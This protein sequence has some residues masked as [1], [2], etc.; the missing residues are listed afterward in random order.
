MNARPRGKR[1]LH[2]AAAGQA[3]GSRRT[4]LRLRVIACAC[5]CAL[6]AGCAEPRPRSVANACEIFSQK[7]HWYEA[8]RDSQQR[9]NIPMALL[10]AFVHQESSFHATARPPRRRLLG[11]IPWVRPSSAYGYAQAV[12]HTWKEYKKETGRTLARRSNFNDA[13]DFIGWYNN[14]SVR[15]LGLR[16]NDARRLYLAYHEGR[17]GYRR[18]S[19]NAKPWL[20]KVAQKVQRR[21]NAY[22]KQLKTCDLKPRPWYRKMFDWRL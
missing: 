15:E 2:P 22:D 10:L 1:Q 8:A 11:I 6:L 21:K 13:M 7:I 19:Y 4:N 18:Q 14:K 16:R 3:A 9:W 5:A 12:D 20:L 17:N